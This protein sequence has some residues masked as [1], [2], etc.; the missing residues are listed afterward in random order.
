MD[1]PSFNPRYDR[2]TRSVTVSFVR[3]RVRVPAGG[4]A[5]GK[6]AW[7]HGRHTGRAGCRIVA[8]WSR[9]RLRATEAPHGRTHPGRRP[10]RIVCLHPGRSRA[11]LDTNSPA[12]LPV[13]RSTTRTAWTAAAHPGPCAHGPEAP[14][15]TRCAVLERPSPGRVRQGRRSGSC[16]L[17]A[18]GAPPGGSRMFGGGGALCCSATKRS[19]PV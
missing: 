16:L 18:T 17:R 4:K 8:T 6:R 10:A 5:S 14:A 9:G 11:A 7:S 2:F 19:S 3:A 13:A 1:P 15:D 12:A